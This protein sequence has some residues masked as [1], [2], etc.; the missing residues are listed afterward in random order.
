[1]TRAALA[2]AALVA[3]LVAGPAT[4]RALDPDSVR[5]GALLHY[6]V[7]YVNQRALDGERPPGAGHA[8]T[9]A[10]FRLRG[11]LGH[12]LPIGYLVG[13]DLHA[14]STS[15]RGFAYQAD[16][17]LAGAGLRLGRV[18]MLGLGTG[19]GASGAVG[20]LDDAVALPLDA[21]VEVALGDHLR[22]LG[23]AHAAWLGAAPARDRGARSAPWTDELDAS[24]ALRVGDRYQDFGFPTGNGYFLGVA[25]REAQGARF[26]GVTL[27]Y[28][29]DLGTR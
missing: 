2:A 7:T 29:V 1:M 10:G 28:S 16:L 26:L 19:V 15:P 27:G 25:Y 18:A 13:L 9:L 21:F 22:V 20:T 24:L 17:Y 8:L 11:F 12:R 3:A 5:G 14:G 4:A 23:R 6:D